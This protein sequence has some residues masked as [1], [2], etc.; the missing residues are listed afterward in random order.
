MNKQETF[1]ERKEWVLR[2]AREAGIV[3]V[4]T[5]SLSEGS[6]ISLETVECATQLMRKNAP[7]VYARLKARWA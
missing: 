6:E 2:E 7:E 1:E 3:D 4:S 5:L